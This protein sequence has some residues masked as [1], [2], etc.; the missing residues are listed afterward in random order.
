MHHIRLGDYARAAG[1]EK[2][3]EENGLV[4]NQKRKDST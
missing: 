2:I 3:Y 4:Q 1:D